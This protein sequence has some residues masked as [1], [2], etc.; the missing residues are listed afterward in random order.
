MTGILFAAALS[1]VP[2]GEAPL[3]QAWGGERLRGL[4]GLTRVAGDDYYAIRD[5]GGLL[6]SLE[7]GVDRA[8]GAVTNCV[9]TGVRRLEGRDDLECVA[10]DAARRCVWT[11]DEGDGSIRAFNP[12]D[13]R[14]RARVDVPK[15]F[16]AFRY[17]FSFEALALHPNGHE[18]WTCNEEA[19][20]RR[21]AVRRTAKGAA[22]VKADTP[23]VDDGPRATRGGGSRVRL[24]R[25][26]RADAGGAWRPAG[27]WMYETDPVGGGGFAG[28]SRSGVAD[29]LCL[30]DGTLFALEREMSIKTGGLLPS[31]RCRI[32]QIDRADADDVSGRVSLRGAACRPVK[33]RRL[34]GANTGFAMYEGICLGPQLADGSWSVLLISDGDDG[35]ANRILSLRLTG[36]R[37]G[38]NVFSPRRP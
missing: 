27:Q 34:F 37:L 38:E 12:A 14:E 4:S 25:F 22:P 26:M 17:N 10:W 13:G 11:A 21:E 31:F 16:D 20:N 28:M 19:L 32:Y 8:T 6:Y 30:A 5:S 29:L 33:K 35:A 3:P 1:L 15:V 23:E 9:I 7:I 2:V 24:Q 18:M 36:A